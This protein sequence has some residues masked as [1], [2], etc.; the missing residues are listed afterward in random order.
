M[1]EV[2]IKRIDTRFENCRLKD[3]RREKDLLTSII[4]QGIREPLQCVIQPEKPL[5][6]LDGFKRLRCSVKLGQ[7]SVPVVSLGCDEAAAILQLIRL[8][9][10]KSLNILEQ[11][12]LVDTLKDTHSMSIV[13]IARHLERSPAWVSVRAG[14]LHEMTP[15]VKD[16]VFSGRFPVRSYMYNLRQFTRVNK[17]K[18]T[19]ID[20]FVTSV[21]GKGLSTRDIETLA[22]GYF[23]GGQQVKEQVQQGNLD[24]TLKQMRRSDI[25]SSAENDSLTDFE[26][27]TIKDLELVQKYMGRVTYE[28]CDGRLQ[29]PS[30]FTTA[31]LLAEGILDKTDFFIKTIQEFYDQRKQKSRDFCPL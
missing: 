13:E 28:L 20:T 25:V 4:E 17:I 6:L 9:N 16:A 22:Y 1:N 26:Q 27:R 14:I 7:F 12:A 3:S 30:F 8:S 15:L 2:E 5:I 24:W 18:N 11:A 31:Y 21:S 23:R 10:E 29:S 19:E